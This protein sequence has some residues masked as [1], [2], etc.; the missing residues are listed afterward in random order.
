MT[1]LVPA[2]VE[3]LRDA[4]AR[5]MTRATAGAADGVASR[6]RRAEIRASVSHT[7]Q[8]NI[9]ATSLTVAAREHVRGARPRLSNGTFA[10]DSGR[11]PRR[12]G[13]TGFDPLRP[14]AS[15]DS[16]GGPCPIPLNKSVFE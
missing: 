16:D 4:S 6:C 5:L 3:E 13:T 9:S 14:I 8:G 12:D 11:L 2:D 7:Q 1:R 10:P 15:A